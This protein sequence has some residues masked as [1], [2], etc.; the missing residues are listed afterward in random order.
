M[1]I[2]IFKIIFKEK[3]RY[4][5]VFAEQVF[6][7]IMLMLSIVSF[8]SF[9]KK[10]N[11]AGTLDTENVLML[12]FVQAGL[13]GQDLIKSNREIYSLLEDLRKSPHVNSISMSDDF[14]PYLKEDRY[15]AHK[16]DSLNVVNKKIKAYFKYTD[17]YAM[18]V[19]KLELIEGRWL[20]DKRLPDGSLPAVISKEILEELGWNSAINKQVNFRNNLYTIVGMISGFKQN[21]LMESVPTLIMPINEN[22]YFNYI[23]VAVRVNDRVAAEKKIYDLKSKYITNSNVQLINIDMHSKFEIDIFNVAGNVY[24]QGIPTIFMLIFAFI[25]TFGIFWFNSRKRVREFALRL[26]LGSTK[27]ALVL[28]VIKE[29]MIISAISMIP[30]LLLSFFIYEFNVAELIGVGATIVIML[31]FAIFSAW[32]PAHQVSRVNPVEAMREE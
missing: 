26:A 23:E 22:N 8:S 1:L 3:K 5:Y 11:E 31:L 17:K 9:F 6:I 14:I 12:G 19:F 30:G 2:H 29:S 10:Y 32:Y 25:G 24:L 7:F 20:D 18:Q 4:I 28:L 13:Q 21:V 16:G 15:Y 27:N